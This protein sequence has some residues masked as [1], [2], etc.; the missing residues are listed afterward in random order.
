[1]FII[2]KKKK[3]K[4]VSLYLGI[5]ERKNKEKKNWIFEKLYNE[6]KD[7]GNNYTLGYRCLYLK[8]KFCIQNGETLLHI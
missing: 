4:N 7:P 6:K 3:K 8:T 5:Q 2:F 1:L